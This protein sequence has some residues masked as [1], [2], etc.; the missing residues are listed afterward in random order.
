MGTVVS[1]RRLIVAVGAMVVSASIASAQLAPATPGDSGIRRAPAPQASE[2]AS[3]DSGR[4]TRVRV[5]SGR[6]AVRLGGGLVAAVAG[7]AGRAAIK[8]KPKHT[9]GKAR[10]RGVAKSSDVPPGSTRFR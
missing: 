9:D 5:R 10:G 4:A 6:S 3:E 7:L 2:P 8:G 1:A